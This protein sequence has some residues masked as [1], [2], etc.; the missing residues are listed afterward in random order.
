MTK[1]ETSVPLETGVRG[2]HRFLWES[3]YTET[4]SALDQGGLLPKSLAIPGAAP[5]R[6]SRTAF[7]RQFRTLGKEF[8]Q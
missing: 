3:S 2:K 6:T 8:P 5:F 4:D 1:G 7:A